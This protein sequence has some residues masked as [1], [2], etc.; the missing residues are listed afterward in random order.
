M[1]EKFYF[2][3]KHE[4]FREDDFRM[5]SEWGFNFVRLPMDY[6]GYI[7]DGDWERFDEAVLKQIDEAVGWGG[8]YGIH[9]CLNLHRAPGWTVARPPEETNLW[10]D[11]EA[12]RVAAKHWAMFARRYKG[13]PNSR[14]S[15]NLFNEPSGIETAAYVA[16]VTAMLEAIRAEDPERLVLCDGIE[17]GR[18]PV[19][20]FIPM[21]VGMMTRG[22]DQFPLTHY[23]A[24]WVG[25]SGRW[26]VPRWPDAAGTNGALLGPAKGD[27]SRPVVIEGRVAA[28]STLR[29]VLGSVSSR[30]TVAVAADGEE[31]WRQEIVAKEGDQRWEKITHKPQWGILQAEGTVEFTIPMVRK[32]KRLELRTVGGDWCAL[33][34]IGIAGPDGDDVSVA[35]E[36]QWDAEQEVLHYNPDSDAGPIFGIRRDRA[37]LRSKTIAPWRKFQQAGGGVMVGEW[38][39]YNKTPHDVCLRWAEDCLHNW[40]EAGWGWALWNFRG[41]F[42][43]LDSGRSDVDYKDYQGHQLDRKLLELLQRY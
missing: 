22:Y 19:W 30:A 43:V 2:R 21:K 7:V 28:G 3:G 1:L 17:W 31:I 12:R 6:R 32:A 13:V 20:E 42:G 18:K 14:L 29:L 25:G 36:N 5:I 4:P 24:G 10:T 9:V 23:K 15:F 11:A 26:P 34:E 8:R 40:Q 41:T 39:V 35:L 38:G 33:S 37:W 27:I 16:V